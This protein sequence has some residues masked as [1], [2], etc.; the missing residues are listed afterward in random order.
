MREGYTASKTSTD[1]DEWQA[2]SAAGLDSNTAHTGLQPDGSKRASQLLMVPGGANAAASGALQQSGGVPNRKS[3]LSTA[4]TLSLGGLLSFRKKPVDGGVIASNGSPVSGNASARKASVLQKRS[5]LQNT[6]GQVLTNDA[7]LP[8]VS[9]L[10]TSVHGSAEMVP[11]SSTTDEGSA[12]AA[13]D[14]E[15][16]SAPSSTDHGPIPL[17][18][19]WRAV[20][21]YPPAARLVPDWLSC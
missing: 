10:A 12:V 3:S 4:I 15:D 21:K 19:P 9:K 18:E 5:S 7:G 1:A 6:P 8:T 2:P 17:V 11:G 14:N 16:G 13:G 20:Y